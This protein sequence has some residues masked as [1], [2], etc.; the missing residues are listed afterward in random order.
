M[1]EIGYTIIFCIGLLE[2]LGWLIADLFNGPIREVLP[3]YRAHCFFQA[4]ND[5]RI[6]GDYWWNDQVLEMLMND[7]G[8]ALPVPGAQK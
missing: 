8:Y 1:Y 3:R 4:W 7:Y 6:S 5:W 2:K